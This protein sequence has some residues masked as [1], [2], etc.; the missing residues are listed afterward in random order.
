MWIAL[1]ATL[2]LFIQ[3]LLGSYALAAGPVQ[4]DIF[5]N[6]I[7]TADGANATHGGGHGSSTLPDCC[8]L[9]CSTSAQLLAN[10]PDAENLVSPPEF[11]AAAIRPL[12]VTPALNDPGRQPGNPRAPPFPA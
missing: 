3:S 4:F 12:P 10:A 9:G 7:C 1:A 5:G 2:A 6:V 8:I 11:A